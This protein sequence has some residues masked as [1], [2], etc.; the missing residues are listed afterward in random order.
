MASKCVGDFA[1]A[2]GGNTLLRAQGRSIA[3]T[4]VPQRRLMAPVRMLMHC[5]AETHSSLSLR[6][7]TDGP[8]HAVLS[9][10]QYSQCTDRKKALCIGVNYTD[11]EEP[12]RLRGCVADTCRMARKKFVCGRRGCKEVFSRMDAV[13]RH[14]KNPNA[15]CA[16][17][18]KFPDGTP[19]VQARGCP[20]SHG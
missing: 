3:I 12:H 20:S 17:H 10:Y 2:E 14:Q 15:R 8:P 19:D 7:G 9:F 4:R 11:C 18:G 5:I 16:A 6:E 13:R 1:R